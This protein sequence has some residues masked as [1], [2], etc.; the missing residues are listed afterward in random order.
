MEFLIILHERKNL[1]VVNAIVWFRRDQTV[2]SRIKTL[3]FGICFYNASSFYSHDKTILVLLL[4]VQ[5]DFDK[6]S[7]EVAFCAIGVAFFK[8]WLCAM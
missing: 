2:V 3:S 1:S 5:N 4:C 8:T 7:L 6:M